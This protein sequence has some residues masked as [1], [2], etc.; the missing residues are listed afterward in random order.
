[1]TAVIGPVN[2]PPPWT[3]CYVA[4]GSNLDQPITQVKRA[5]ELLRAIDATQ[6]MLTS[7][8]YESAP[9]GPIEQPQFINAVVALLT[10]L[11]PAHMLDQLQ[12]IERHMGRAPA[13]HW[14][15]RVIDLD[16]LM[17]GD[18]RCDLPNLKLP[19]A[20]LLQRNFVMTPLAEIAPMLSVSRTQTAL[21]LA[22]KLGSTGL[23]RL[24]DVLQP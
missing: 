1:M 18:T 22:R 3:P 7:S 21:Q 23:R 9:M 15:P 24:D 19:H 11:S 4:L 12:A 5:C 2:N 14:G 6:L 8:L 16:L 10:Q 20:G 17:H 13:A